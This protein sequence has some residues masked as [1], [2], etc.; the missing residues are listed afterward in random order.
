LA[1]FKGFETLAAQNPAARESHL[2]L[3][4]AALDAQLWGEARRHLDEALTAAAPP[5]SKPPRL[6]EPPGTTFDGEGL[7]GPTPRVCLMMARLEEAEH[8]AGES[9]REWLDRAVTAMPDPH[10]VCASCGGESLQWRSVCPHCGAFDRLAWRTPA[11][12][13]PVAALPVAAG[14]SA[15]ELRRLP[16][17]NDTP[18]LDRAGAGGAN[19]LGD[20]A[21]S[22]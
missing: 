12:S 7:A 6:G 13:G 16:A 18:R 1:R 21:I 10:Y 19:Q 8:G 22:R 9:M 4:E 17:E 5:M 14:V 3:A 2:A 15:S 20:G 11:W